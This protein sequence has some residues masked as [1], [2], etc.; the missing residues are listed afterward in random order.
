GFTAAQVSEHSTSS[1]CW[2]IINGEVYDITSYISQHPGGNVITEA[3]GVDGTT[4]FNTQGGEG[5]HSPTADA[6]LSSFKIGT[7][8]N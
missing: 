1:D 7:L 4:A 8:A 2:T 3:C 5:S 6:L